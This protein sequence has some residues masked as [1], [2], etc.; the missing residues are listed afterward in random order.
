MPIVV[1]VAV[2]VAVLFRPACRTSDFFPEVDFGPTLAEQTA[3]NGKV[4]EEV[5]AVRYLVC[6]AMLCRRAG[7]GAADKAVRAP[8][9]CAH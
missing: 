7:P 6:W 4:C 2:P 3:V 1:A 8:I 9:P 5:Y